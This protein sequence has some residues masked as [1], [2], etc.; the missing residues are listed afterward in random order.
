[1]RK[2]FTIGVLTTVLAASLVGAS[3][4]AGAVEF[5]D[6]CVGNGL[7]PPDEI[8]YTLT[9]LSSPGP[10]P[11]TAPSG[12]VITK[13]RTIVDPELGFPFA[14]PTSIK[15]LRSAG[16]LNYT[17]TAATTIGVTAGTNLTNVRLPVQTGDR[18]ALHGIPFTYEGTEVPS[19]TIYCDEVLGD[20]GAAIGEVGVGTTAPFPPPAE[21]R[22]PLAAIVEADVDNDGYGDETQ[23]LC[24]QSA[25]FQ[26][27]C[28]AVVVDAFSLAGGSAVR[29]L[30]ATST[31]APV[32]VSG[33]VKLGKSDKATLSAKAKVVPAGKIVAFTLK[34]PGPLKEKLKELEPSKKLQL[35]I[36]ASATN[37]AGAV[38][39]D[40]LKAKLKGQG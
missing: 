4:A 22:V 12:G 11:L 39:T 7:A 8:G 2:R 32:K 3:G 38:S 20:L 37:V 17:V 24:P 18:L 6:N 40:R 31:S 25:A 15:V 10:L 33:T 13:I 16:G 14:V 23:D 5:G 36:V 35:K 9:S 27:A 19:F 30:V 21:G 34:F 1:M 28:P 29:V 26:T